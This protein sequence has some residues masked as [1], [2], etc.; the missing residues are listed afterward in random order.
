MRCGFLSFVLALGVQLVA[1]LFVA[2]ADL[3]TIQER[4]YLIV[5]VKDNWRPLGFLDEQGELIGFEIAIA[6]RLAET[7]FDDATALV[8]QPLANEDRLAA[9]LNGNVDIAIAGI[10][11]TPMRERVVRFS[12]PYYL[13]GTAF[14]T[15]RPDIDSLSDLEQAEIALLE[16]SDSV[17]TIQY[18]L[19]SAILTGVSS[20]Q[21][22]LDVMTEGTVSAFAGDVT[23]LSGWIQ[24]YPNHRLLPEILTAEPLAIAFPKGNQYN[25]LRRFI[26]NALN[27]WHQEGWLEAEATSWGLP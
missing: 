22:G 10:A 21:A 12:V 26:N 8:F 14:V 24:E 1:P 23:V 18:R 9:V 20:Y 13:D 6:T 19:P 2:A 27:E 3:E 17:P 4:G 5:A 7:L 15:N 16:G 25:N 11:V